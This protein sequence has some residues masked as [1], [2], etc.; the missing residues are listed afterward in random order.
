M[1]CHLVQSSCHCILW[2]L[3]LAGQGGPSTLLLN[4]GQYT[5]T[6]LCILN[7]H[8]AGS[9]NKL[10]FEDPEADVRV[11]RWRNIRK[12][13]KCPAFD[14]SFTL[15]SWTAD[16]LSFQSHL[17]SS[18]PSSHSPN[19]LNLGQFVLSKAP[20][21]QSKELTLNITFFTPQLATT[22]TSI[23]SKAP[24]DICIWHSTLP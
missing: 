23:T 12:E 24:T 15:W 2:N 10:E 22:H 18:L 1:S 3:R 17:L 8:P 9:L 7:S 11:W 19:A 20:K 14:I 16:S 4:A 21:P 5:S 13:G 6:H